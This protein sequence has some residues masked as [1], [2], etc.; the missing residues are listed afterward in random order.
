MLGLVLEP[1]E[2]AQPSSPNKIHS[3][4]P[5]PLLAVLFG[6]SRDDHSR[7]TG[8]LEAHGSPV[9]GVE[10]AFAVRPRRHGMSSTSRSRQNSL[11]HSRHVWVCLFGFAGTQKKG[12]RSRDTKQKPTFLLFPSF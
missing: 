5:K 12:R 1:F 8:I 11:F 6:G 10:L 9:L 7:A 2:G 3:H 4:F